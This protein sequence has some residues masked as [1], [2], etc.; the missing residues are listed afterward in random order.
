MATKQAKTDDQ[1]RADTTYLT[2]FYFSLFLGYLGVDRFYMGQV[3][4]GI[5]KLLTIGGLG[6][7]WVIDI[8]WIGLGN[9]KNKKGELIAR[10]DRTVLHAYIGV[11]ILLI[12]GVTTA[13]TSTISY[14]STL[15]SFDQF[16]QKFEGADITAT[17][18][19]RDGDG[20]GTVHIKLAE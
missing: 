6:I 9:A 16:V 7:W 3:G 4:F 20:R 14:E 12:V 2:A 1:Y 8:I 13:I 11:G 19:G 18:E 15:D 10:T 17:G 5:L